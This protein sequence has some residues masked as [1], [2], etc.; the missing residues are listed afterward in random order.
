MKVMR[1]FLFLLLAFPSTAFS[2][3]FAQ[4][5]LGGGYETIIM[6]S[7]RSTTTQWP[8]YKLRQGSGQP[9]NGK[10]TAN[11]TELPV[12]DASF[13]SIIADHQTAKIVLRGD[14]ITRTGYLEIEPYDSNTNLDYLAISYFYVFKENGV[15][16]TSAGSGP[17]SLGRLL[18]FPAERM[19]RDRT[20][21]GY[22]ISPISGTPPFQVLITIYHSNG[23]ILGSKTVNY[24]GYMC[25]FISQT[26]PN[27]QNDFVGQVIISSDH[28]VYV[29]VLR[30]ES[31]PTTF[32]LTSTPASVP[33]VV[34]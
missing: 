7:N 9:W 33:A 20:D 8:R 17:S 29:E 13:F 25:E 16:K 27:L 23:T 1:I 4:L 22:A 11:Y 26:F 24:T 31:T 30:M 14:S 15:T 28:P 10:W 18:A 21:T 3:T 2:I 5:A 12:S 19:V 6:V 34:Y 32:L